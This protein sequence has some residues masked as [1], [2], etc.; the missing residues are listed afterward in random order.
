MDSAY[1][2]SLGRFKKKKPAELNETFDFF[3][4]NKKNG[5]PLALELG[6]GEGFNGTIETTSSPFNL[7]GLGNPN[8]KLYSDYI[9]IKE[10]FRQ[11]IPKNYIQIDLTQPDQIDLG[12]IRCHF[13]AARMVFLQENTNNPRYGVYWPSAE[14]AEA[15]IKAIFNLLLPNGLLYIST[16]PRFPRAV[17]INH[18]LETFGLHRVNYKKIPYDIL[19]QKNPD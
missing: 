6:S 17:D 14:V 1:S 7:S 4:P 8:I 13:I 9:S 11:R 12:G 18:L 15:S 19:I 3:N 2:L 5:F 10:L 16:L